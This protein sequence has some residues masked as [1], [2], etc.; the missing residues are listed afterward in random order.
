MS[1]SEFSR[2]SYRNPINSPIRDICSGSDS[3]AIIDDD[4]GECTPDSSPEG[5]AWLTV[6]Y[7]KHRL[8]VSLMREVY[9]ICI[10]QWSTEFRS[11]GESQTGGT[12]ASLQSSSSRTPS[13]TAK[14]KR[15]MDDQDSDSPDTNNNKK[16]RSNSANSDDVSKEKLFACCFYK[17]NALKYCVNSETG[18]KYRSCAGPG[19]G[20][21]S[22]LK[23]VDSGHKSFTQQEYLVNLLSG[24]ISKESTR[25]RSTAP[26]AGLS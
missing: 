23:C 26:D 19:F 4:Y 3:G 15:K 11:R 10:S 18:M 22:Q 7:E 6:A 20:K 21:I 1:T 13:S 2:P 16:K 17:Y 25:R 12:G 14:G 24:N 9:T 5:D 8:M